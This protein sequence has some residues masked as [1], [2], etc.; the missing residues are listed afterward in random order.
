MIG[1]PNLKGLWPLSDGNDLSGCTQHLIQ[2]NASNIS[3][4]IGQGVLGNAGGTTKN[5]FTG[6]PA[7]LYSDNFT[8]AF[9]FRPT[10]ISSTA[11][12][13]CIFTISSVIDIFWSHAETYREAVTLYNGS[14]W[15]GY[16]WNTAIPLNTWTH[17][18]ITYDH[19][20][21]KIYI[22]GVLM[23]DYAC[24]LTLANTFSS[25]AWCGNSTGSQGPRSHAVN[26]GCIF[27]SAFSA[28]EIQRLYSINKA[29][30]F[31]S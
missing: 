4:V 27:K 17:F 31:R 24:A 12:Y 30:L 2:T 9:W 10:S 23:H 22:N 15:T 26:M 20:R 3:A 14:T 6:A 28:A 5:V 11:T 7:L 21:L 16:K 19:S 25:I 18:A 13:Q 8:I 1:H 29:P